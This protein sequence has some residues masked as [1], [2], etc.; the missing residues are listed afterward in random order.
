MVQAL[1]DLRHGSRRWA[2]RVMRAALA[3]A[4]KPIEDLA[5]DEDSK[6]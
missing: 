6:Q 4:V 2:C 3:S 5:D 1:G